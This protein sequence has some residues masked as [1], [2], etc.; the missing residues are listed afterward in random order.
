MHKHVAI[1]SLIGFRWNKCGSR[2][3]VYTLHVYPGE[4]GYPGTPNASGRTGTNAFGRTGGTGIAEGTRNGVFSLARR[5]IPRNPRSSSS[6]GTADI[7]MPTTELR[8]FSG[9]Q[10]A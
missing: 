9:M 3:T 10:Q 2:Y 8:N 4:I 6:S 1:P 5:G 7:R